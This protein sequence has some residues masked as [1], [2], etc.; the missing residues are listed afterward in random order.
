MKE[1]EVKTEQLAGI[2]RKKK[3]KIEKT[4]NKEGKK[5]TIINLHLFP[6]KNESDAMKKT[7]KEI[8]LSNK[9]LNSHSTQGIYAIEHP[10]T[11]TQQT[12]YF[13]KI[14]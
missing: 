4:C 8:S 1:Q 7:E 3:K 11:K 14:S 10:P 2:Q 5:A 12:F 13:S 9:M 6:S